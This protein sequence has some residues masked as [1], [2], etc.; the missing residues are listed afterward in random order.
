MVSNLWNRHSSILSK[1]FSETLFQ[2]SDIFL[3]KGRAKHSL[4]CLP[5]F[6]EV[7]VEAYEVFNDKE[8]T[9]IIVFLSWTVP[10]R[11]N[12]WNSHSPKSLRHILYDF[13]ERRRVFLLL[14][15]S[16]INNVYTSFV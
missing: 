9:I 15:R 4:K 1:G 8:P 3:V 12:R 10:S 6:L 14:T 16:T 7:K 11:S 2:H 5:V 13:I